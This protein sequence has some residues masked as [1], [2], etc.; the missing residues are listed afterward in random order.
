[1]KSF[2]LL[3]LLGAGCLVSGCVTAR[4]HTQDE[5]NSVTRLCGLELGELIQD[6]MEKK[7]LIALRTGATAQQRVC[8]TR[9]ARRNGLK[10]VFVDVQFPAG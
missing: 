10:P 2:G 9:W 6:E 1:M 8:V 7:V 5:L 3:L 4:M